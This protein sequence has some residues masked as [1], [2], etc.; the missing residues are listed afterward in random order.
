MDEYAFTALSP[1]L[2]TPI[3]SRLEDRRL[4]PEEVARGLRAYGVE[5]EPWWDELERVIGGVT[6][7]ESYE[8]VDLGLICAFG[9]LFRTGELR[10]RQTTRD[11]RPLLRVGCEGDTHYYL[12][13]NGEAWA[14]DA[15]ADR[16]P[17]FE[18]ETLA[19]LADHLRWPIAEQLLFTFE[20]RP[21]G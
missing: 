7:G 2:D 18:R 8:R 17:H 19:E 11:G 14:L 15:I 5:P 6:F 21:K 3:V 9:E 20:R 10:Y 13:P 4:R 1:R 16:H 12:A